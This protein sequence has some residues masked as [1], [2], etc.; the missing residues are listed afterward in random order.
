MKRIRDILFPEGTR[1]RLKLRKIN[2]KIHG[3]GTKP[4]DD[5]QLWIQNNEPDEKELENQRNTQFKLN[6]KISIITPMYNTPV[7]FFNELVDSLID[8]T[9]PNWE[10]CLGDGSPKKNDELEEIC[11]KD[12][13]IKYHFIGENKGISGNTNEALKLVTGNYIALLDHDDLLPKFSLF[14]VVKCING[15]PDADFIYSDE[16]KI[17]EKDGKR[18]DPNFKPDFAPDT[19]RSNNYICHFSVLKKELMDKLGG[20]RSEYDGSQDHD[21]FLRMSET[22]DKIVH[23][24][25]VL[26]HWRVYELSTSKAG[27]NAKPY[28]YI[29]GKKAV[30]DHINRLGLKGTVEFGKTMGTY[31]VNYKIIGNPKVSI[32]IPNKDYVSTLKTCLKSITELTTYKNYE[33]IIVEN[34]STEKSTFRYYKKI[35]QNEK[36]KVIYF[37]EKEFNYS[38]IINFGVKHSKGDYIIQ[39]N[40]DTKIITPNWIE[41]MLGFAQRKDVGAVGVRLIYPDKS[42][43]HVGIII[44]MGGIA[45]HVFKGL[46]NKVN[47]YF[48]KDTLIQNLSAVTAA[49]IM[50]PRYIYDE[51]G[52][53]DEKFKVAFNDVD[54]CLKIREKGKL[55]VMNPFVQLFHYESKSR[56]Y[57]DTPEKKARFNSEIERFK[58]KWPDILKNGD[59]YY[60]KNLRIDIDQF[61]ITTGKV[62]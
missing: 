37:P 12:S 31:K 29:A 18:Y 26:Y 46:P 60:N 11:K 32:I 2:D 13:R 59:P 40:N 34:N 15:N 8:Q 33:I 24:P 53:M 61:A 35:E 50:N 22:T 4:L 43:Q 1:I 5:Y 42:I 56:G 51:V 3:T 58:E 10:L 14:E 38:K 62:E 6:P 27:G 47:A 39:L 55:I 28:A 7:N 23:I 48:A 44:G 54:F 9:Y 17:E 36:I 52:F 45:G 41:E 16:D 25:K 57:E 19:L 20:F 49:C 30:Q 21:L